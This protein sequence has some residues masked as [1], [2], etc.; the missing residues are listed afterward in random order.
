M[1]RTKQF[2]QIGEF[3]LQEAVLDVL[4]DAKRNGEEEWVRLSDISKRAG[5]YRER[6]VFTGDAIAGGLL[7]KLYSEKRVEHKNKFGWKLADAE[8]AKRK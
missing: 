4:L 8:F 3:L 2:A 1:I 6:E 5:I 7:N